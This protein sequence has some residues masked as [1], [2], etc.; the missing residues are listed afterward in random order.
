MPGAF[1]ELEE[2]RK[3]SL[4]EDL[5]EMWS[6]SQADVGFLVSIKVRM[7]FCLKLLS[8]RICPVVVQRIK[9]WKHLNLFFYWPEPKLRT[10]E[11]DLVSTWHC[12][13]HTCTVCTIQGA[14]GRGLEWRPSPF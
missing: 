8:L 14:R 1:Q 3:H 11:Q 2:A 13:G 5:E 7:N 9:A 6:Y 4:L 12:L 10:I